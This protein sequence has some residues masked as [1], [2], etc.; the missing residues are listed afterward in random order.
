[1]KSFLLSLISAMALVST[2]Y[3]APGK[4]NVNAP[5][6]GTWNYN[7][8]AEP[9]SLHPIMAG[10]IYS[11][12]LFRYLHDSLCNNSLETWEFQPRLAEKWEISKDGLTFT[13]HLRKDAY[14][15]NGDPV[16]ADDVKFSLDAIREP[17]HQALNQLPYFEKITK[18]EVIDKYT[19]KFTASEKY[20]K[21]L[22]SLCLMTIIPKS[23][24][25]NVDKSVKMQKETIGAGP[26]KLDKYEKGQNITISRFDKW[27]GKSEKTL[28]GFFNFDKIVFRFTKEDNILIERLKKGDFDFAELSTES[29]KKA[30]GPQF[31]KTVFANKVENSQPKGYGFIGFNFK[32][33][34]LKDKAVRQA[35]AHLVNREA[36][37]K[38]FFNGWNYL[39]TSPVYVKSDQAPDL[40]PI[41]FDPKKAQELLQKA[42]WTDSDKNGILDKMVNGKKQE[43]RFSWIYSSKDSEKF[44]TIV[45]EDAKQAGI[46]LDLKLLE[47]NSFI[48]T[49]DDKNFDLISMGWGGGDVESDPKQ[50]WHSASNG[51]GGSNYINYANVEADKLINDGRT[52][53]DKTKR[54]KIFK[55][56]YTVIAEDVPY[57]FMFNRKFE[58]YANSN[59]I[60][61]P[62]ETLKYDFGERT[63]W[64]AAAKATK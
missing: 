55:K 48:K 42:G 36:M 26:Y 59:K 47:W 56:L 45:K 24:Y 6:G 13:F 21:N 40:K 37:N 19:I 15:H 34:A 46:V 17:K 11:S 20:F 28:D 4:P 49:V 52:E 33:E 31:G 35:F 10:D 3:A 43:L 30:V 64:S 5:K 27:Y 12:R 29:Y 44:W 57:V 38:K 14:F 51:K 54:N 61:K 7:F 22:E 50:I 25:G 9:E 41:S 63:W 62:A 60:S 32:N 53:L 39:A 8:D 2:V 16:T 23:V 1:M 18:V 58:Y